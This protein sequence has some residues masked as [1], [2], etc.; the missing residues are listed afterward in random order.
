MSVAVTSSVQKLT[1]RA[2]AGLTSVTARMFSA[3]KWVTQDSRMS[4]C[5]PL[6]IFS[7]TSSWS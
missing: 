4:M 2:K 1:R 3:R 5:I 6:R 7:T